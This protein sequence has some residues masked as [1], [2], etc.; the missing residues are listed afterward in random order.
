[1]QSEGLSKPLTE[2]PGTQGRAG[3]PRG[4]GW[5]GPGCSPLS[6]WTLRPC[7]LKRVLGTSLFIGALLALPG[8]TVGPNYQKPSS[9]MPAQWSEGPPS[10]TSEKFVDLSHWWRVFN[11]PQLNSLIDRAVAANKELKIAEARIM[12][13]RALRRVVASELYPQV[14]LVGSYSRSRRSENTISSSGSSGSVVTGSGGS[15]SGSDL[16]QAG[17]DASWEI[18]VFGGTR[19]AVEAADA[20]VQAVQE[21]YRDTLVTLLAEVAR[22]YLEVRGNQLRKAI[23]EKNLFLE[24]RTLEMAKERFEVG[25]SSELDVAQARA[26]LAATE[27]RIPLLETAERQAIHRLGVLLGSE[28]GL[29]IQELSK[30]APLPVGPPE[31]P[32]GVPSDLLRRRPDIR[33]AEREVAAATARIG[34]ATADLFPRFYLNGLVGQQSTDWSDFTGSSS[35][36]WS[37]G[38]TVTWP[39]FAGGKIRAAIALRGAQQEASLARYERAV[40]RALEDVENS[41]VAFQKE[42]E[43]RRSLVQVVEA[44]KQAFEISNELYVQGLVDFLNVVVNQRTLNTSEDELAQSSQRVSSNLVALFKALGGGWEGESAAPR[45]VQ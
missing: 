11:D 30:V 9:P 14:D 32:V 6:R 31:I 4:D 38:P 33:Q 18:D 40:L 29:L 5:R 22:N 28:P 35:R 24:R 21:N 26:Q 7:R 45:E 39:L 16:F 34:V 10:V 15:S 44:S 17:F 25:L 27:A 13:A 42:Q 20:D 3:V 1:M 37:I 12:E 8:C 2:L 19:R 36:F 23:A 41:L 43:T